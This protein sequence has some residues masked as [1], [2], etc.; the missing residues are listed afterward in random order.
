M[1]AVMKALGRSRIAEIV[2]RC[3]DA[4]ANLVEG[5]GS[6]SLPGAEVLSPAVINQADETAWFGSTDWRGKRAMRIS[7]CSWA[8]GPGDVRKTVHAVRAGAHCT[9]DR[10]INV[11][12][13]SGVGATGG[14]RG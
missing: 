11:T 7:V 12:E 3:S 14:E 2:E 9:G 1:Y 10:E 13:T 4:A 8:T 6:R 5:I